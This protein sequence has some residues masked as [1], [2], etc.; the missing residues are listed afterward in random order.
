MF[1]D[2]KTK[3]MFYKDPVDMRKS[4]D[5]LCAVITSAIKEGLHSGSMFVFM[6]KRGD[7][8]KILLWDRNGFCLYYKRLEKLKFK[9]PKIKENVLVIS[10]VEL[11]W[12]LDGLDIGKLAL[13]E[14]EKYSKIY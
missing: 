14:S 3:V 10:T 11:R 13:T 6:N 2:N 5:G 9:K 1:L 12:L 8:I 7:K 4:I